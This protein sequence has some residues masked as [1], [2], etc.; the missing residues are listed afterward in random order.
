MLD[1]VGA[2]GHF[3]DA[4]QE[5]LNRYI[6]PLIEKNVDMIWDDEAKAT[7]N[8]YFGCHDFSS[9]NWCGGGFFIFFIVNVDLEF[10]FVHRKS[11]SDVPIMDVRSLKLMQEGWEG[12]SLQNITRL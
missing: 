11:C 1:G 6:M 10:C 2:A 8:K 12:I 3:L 9:K 7:Q 5:D 4:L